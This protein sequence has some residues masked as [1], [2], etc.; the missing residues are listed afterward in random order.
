[1]INKNQPPE[2]MNWG[3]ASVDDEH[4]ERRESLTGSC[5][6]LDLFPAIGNRAANIRITYRMAKSLQKRLAQKKKLA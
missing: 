3:G 4:P 5:A 2:S 6:E 1:L